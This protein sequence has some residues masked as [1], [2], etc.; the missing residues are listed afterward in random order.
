MGYAPME[1][2]NMEMESG[3]SDMNDMNDMELGNM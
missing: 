2:G 3:N 1:I